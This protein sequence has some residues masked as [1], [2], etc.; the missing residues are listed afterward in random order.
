MRRD[1]YKVFSEGKIASLKLKNRLVRSATYEGSMTEKGVATDQMLDLYKNF[2]EG[3]VGMIITGHM[4]VML[5]G[6]GMA[7][8]TCIYD[9]VYIDE[10]ARIADAVHSSGN[11]CKVVAQLSHAGRQVTHDNND[12]ECVGPSDVPS[13]VLKKRAR[14]LST[15]EVQ[16][17]VSRFTDAIVRV[18][19][20][21]YDA[22][23]LHAA[24]GYLLSSFLSPYTNHRSDQYGGS[25]KNRANILREII[26]KA[27]EKVADFPILV[28]VNCDDNVKGGIDIDIFPEMA[29]EIESL[30][31][32]A[33]EVSGGMWDCLARTENELGFFPL[34]IPEAHTRIN[35]LDKQSYFLK[36]HYVSRQG[37]RL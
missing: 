16:N 6:K 36:M 1:K 25:L 20:A 8:Q 4:T 31:F 11:G 24:H 23:Q 3:G 12:A 15:K 7:K 33:I 28:K 26:N 27:R 10:I 22:L 13:P 18:N 32:D 5:E 17:I 37:S 9:D 34:P 14:A 19:K 30:G 29:K 35:S 21:G 2:A